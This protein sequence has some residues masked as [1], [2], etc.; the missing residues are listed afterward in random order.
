ML[1]FSRKYWVFLLVFLFIVMLAVFV[2]AVVF[3]GGVD[4]IPSRG[5]YILM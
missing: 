2:W 4:K 3:S 1:C 5:V